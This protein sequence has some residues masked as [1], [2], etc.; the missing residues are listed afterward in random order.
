MSLSIRCRG[1][2]GFLFLELMKVVLLTAP[3]SNR[4]ERSGIIFRSDP[5]CGVTFLLSKVHLVS[6][7]R[8]KLIFFSNRLAPQA[9]C[10]LSE[11][12]ISYKCFK[13]LSLADR[14]TVKL[15]E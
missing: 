9:V 7:P 12:I 2:L 15:T 1:M 11:L 4:S 10:P 14:N 5:P 8:G 3:C 13:T 6:M